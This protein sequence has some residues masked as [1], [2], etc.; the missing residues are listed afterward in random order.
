MSRPPLL[1]PPGSRKKSLAQ[2]LG[3]ARPEGPASSAPDPR[4]GYV[5]SFDGTRLFYCVEGE[6]PPLVFCYGLVCSSL[7][8]TYQ[9][10][11]FRHTHRTVW[12]DYRGHHNS[13][14]P[15]DLKALTLGNFARDVRAVM[16]E[17]QIPRA[18]LLGH[19]M[20][21]NV[22]LELYRQSPERVAAMVLANGTACRP[23]ETLLHHNSLQTAFRLIKK[24]YLRYPG[25]VRALWSRQ[26]SNPVIRNLIRLGGFNPYLTPQADIDEYLDSVTGIDAGI[27][28]HL[29]EDYDTCDATAWLH[30]VEAPTL[31]IAGEHDKVVPIEQQQLMRQLMPRSRL[32][33]IHHGSHCPQMDLPELVSG[34]IDAFLSELAWR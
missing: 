21:V 13:E 9:I 32:E 6:G 4:H 7:H 19:S 8:W 11:H 20:G 24:A 28:L 33:V 16:D 22:V 12:L 2:R 29:I 27:F 1:R 17:L 10:E 34:K 25:V 30:T 23:L 15:R 26:K 3:R 14:T 18:V 31:I 5:R